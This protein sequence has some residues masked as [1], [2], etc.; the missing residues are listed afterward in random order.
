MIDRQ[1]NYALQAVNECYTLAVSSDI[2][3]RHEQQDRAG[4]TLTE[5][6]GV[7]AVCDGM[8]GHRGGQRASLLA[9]E[10][11]L[12][13]YKKRDPNQDLRKFLL[14]TVFSIDAQ[15]AALTEPDGSATRGGTTLSA[16]LLDNRTL[17]WVSVGDSRI[18]VYRQPELVQITTDHTFLALQQS[19]Q[20]P[21]NLPPVE[22]PE[23]VLVSF[24]G[25]RQPPR[26]ERN[27]EGLALQPG[28]VV[29]L[30]TD[31]LH[32]LLSNE[33]IARTLQDHPLPADAAHT[34][35]AAALNKATATGH[36]ADNV[37]VAVLRVN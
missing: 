5:V 14:E 8:G 7:I 37:T 28:D 6:G 33:E 3:H 26:I 1:D 25:I 15:I 19:G 9:T 21:P 34:L 32:K 29:L 13:A 17:H 20:L 12:R 23:S 22:H 2:G 10:Q 35:V 31:G 30:A 24:L 4:Y 16:V 36:K 18:Y 11:L 27:R